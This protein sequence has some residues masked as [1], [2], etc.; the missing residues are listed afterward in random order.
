MNLFAIYDSRFTRPAPERHDAR[1]SSIVNRDWARVA[2]LAFVLL[3]L[4]A[5]V[6]VLAQANFASQGG[7][8]GIA[9]GLLGDQVFPDASFKTSGGFLVWEDNAT[10][11]DGLGISARR[12]DRGFSGTLSSF[13]VNQQGA[14]DQE[15]PRVAMLNDGGAVFVWQGGQQGYQRV[16]A[17]FLSMSNTWVTGDVLVNTFTN[18]SQLS[19]AVAVLA[20][21]NVVVVWTSFDQEAAGS[22]QGV[23]A[24]L[25]SPTGAK[26]GGEFRINQTAAFNQRLPALATL[27]D[28]RFVVAWVS[29]QQRFENS[30]DI[31]A[32]F[33]SAAGDAAGN[34]FLINTSTNVTGH[35][36]VAAGADGSFLVAWS[37]CDSLN[38]SNNW[39]VVARPVWSGGTAGVTR[40]INTT[41]YG[42]QIAPRVSAIGTDYLVVWMSL[43]QDGSREGVYGQFLRGDGFPAGS[44]FRVNTTTISQQMH[45]AVVSDGSGR[46]LAVWTSFVGGPGSF[47]LYA[48][49]YESTTQPL[50]APD[51]PLVTVLSSNTLSIIWPEMA[52]FSVDH[53]E[54]YADGAATATATVT[55]NSWTM[56]GL[57]AGST[58]YFR[59]AYVLTDD[60]RSPLSGATTN[61]TYG[62][63][64]YGGIPYEWMV[65]Y[66]GGDVFGWPSPFADNDGDGVDNRNEFLAGTDPKDAD[67]VLRIRLQPTVQ[68]MF[69]NWNT[70][71]G[72]MYQVQSSTNLG[73]WS[74]VGG[75]RFAADAL[76]SMYVGGGNVGYY[77][78]L[79][80]R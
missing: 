11:G 67:S 25:L 36:S 5:P 58:H 40:R 26:L 57:G 3:L 69:L 10:D 31:Y 80:L 66:F 49:R 74:N 15:R 56:S 29:E 68:G 77:R 53:Y 23:Y 14:L 17:R 38:R 64:T 13:R 16:Y 28:G 50:L 45:P 1:Q 37:E 21:G 4:L 41:L 2:R 62:A 48:Q 18:N 9:G 7:E 46:F 39:D 55:S 35:P 19:P 75:A 24:Q 60:R 43:G 6:A 65:Y 22:L 70:E 52:G 63:L 42:D 34:E 20:N 72:L 54:V 30:V 51:P 61:A 79:R 76:D 73:T 44:E 47:D 59:L 78:V 33:Y 71:P 27:A 32:R 8:Y 12:L